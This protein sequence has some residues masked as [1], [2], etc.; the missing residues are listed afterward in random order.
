MRR[1][2]PHL[3]LLPALLCAL[4]AQAQSPTASSDATE[5]MPAN[6]S[7]Y[8]KKAPPP[9]PLAKDGRLVAPGSTVDANDALDEMLDEFAADIARMGAARVSPILLERIRVSDNMNPEFAAI[10]EARL[11]AA[12][13][14]AANVAVVRCFECY[15]TRGEVKDGQWVVQRGVTR[16][17]ELSQ[18][19]DKYSAQ[20][21]LQA[22]LT[23]N[24]AP[25]SLAL[26]V[27]MVRA[28]DATVAFAEG[29]RVHPYT[30]M[31]YRTADRV[32]TREAKL[33]DLEDRVNARPQWKYS[34]QTGAAYVPVSEHPD[35]SFGAA[36]VAARFTEAFGEER[37]WRAGV[38]VGGLINPA[39][40]AGLTLA[41]TMLSRLTED[42][43]YKVQCFLGGSAGALI[44]GKENNS[45]FFG[46]QAECTLTHRF[47]L[48]AS[49]HYLIP[50]KVERDTGSYK[51]GGIVPQAGV[52]LVW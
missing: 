32:Q 42:N 48:Q 47:T 10:L 1:E 38:T 19:A 17:E 16:K 52:A 6:A 50:F 45:P 14:R 9:K 15:A 34:L 25:N 31:L 36:Y 12:V 43:I 49:V 2:V 8:R 21:L 46:P 7:I 18:L 28:S 4:T 37:N 23:L 30:A 29:Y 13:Y 35:G 39:R 20:M 51:V 44:T 41:A 22:N 11:V 26:D 40:M 5:E 3:L 33:K 24:T 27:E